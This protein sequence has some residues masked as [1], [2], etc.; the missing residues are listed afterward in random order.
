MSPQ[1]HKNIIWYPN[2]IRNHIFLRKFIKKNAIQFTFFFDIFDKFI[3]S[4][5]RVVHF[6]NDLY[7]GIQKKDVDCTYNNPILQ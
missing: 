1:S 7:Y 4:R 2:F 3:N 5:K 6:W